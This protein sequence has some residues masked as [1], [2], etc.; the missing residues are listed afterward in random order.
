[1]YATAPREPRPSCRLLQQIHD[2]VWWQKK[3]KWIR[4]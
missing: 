4:I 1:M 3:T 2:A